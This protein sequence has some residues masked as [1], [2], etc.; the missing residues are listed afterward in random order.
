MGVEVARSD[1]ARVRGPRLSAAGLARYADAALV[2]VSLATIT[3]LL[4]IL[5]TFRYGRDQGIYAVVGNV[6]LS[7]GAPYRDAWDFKPPFI[8]FIYAGARGLFGP[9]MIAIRLVEALGLVSLVIAFAVLSRRFVGSWRAGLVG[10]TLAVFLHVKLEFWHT[11]QPESFGGIIVAWA[12][13]CATYVAQGTSRKAHFRQYGA[14][15]ATGALYTI[16]ALLKPPL[17]GGFVISLGFVLAEQRRMLAPSER[18]KGLLGVCAAF[19][20]GAAV[21]LGAMLSFFAFKGSLAELYETFFVFTP[22]YTGLGFEPS[23]LPGLLAD[24][25]R[26]GI[27]GFSFLV[28]LGLAFLAG[29]TSRGDR[30]ISGVLQVLGVVSIQLLGVAMQ[31]KFFDYHYGASLPLLSL[32]AGWGLWK[33][34][35]RAFTDPF[36]V[37]ATVLLVALV[38]DHAPRQSTPAEGSTGAKLYARTQLLVGNSSSAVLDWLHSKGDV[39]FGANVEMAR[40]LRD[41]T[42]EDDTVFIWGFEPMVYDLA[43]RRFA[44]RYIYNVPQRLEWPGSNAARAELMRDLHRTQPDVVLVTRG[45]VFTHVTGDRRDSFAMLDEFDELG[46]FLDVGYSLDGNIQDFMIYTRRPRPLD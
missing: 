27:T 6:V 44:S 28:P 7:G 38:V 9:G 19:G 17:G 31:A 3:Y 43:G 12:I 11:A 26:Q 24:A 45:D 14:W 35:E 34:W 10:A 46:R 1:A 29:L 21:I 22:Q 30:A 13:V 42:D 16:A 15:F 32:L 18:T 41:N 8:Y 20:L 37:A 39:S 2:V 33:L 25:V 5:L 4:L 36:R 23:K 40:W